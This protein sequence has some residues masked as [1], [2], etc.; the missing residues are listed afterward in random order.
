LPVPIIDPNEFELEII[1]NLNNKTFKF[2]LEDLKKN[3]THHTV[4]N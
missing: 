4:S 2:S 1:D 3:F